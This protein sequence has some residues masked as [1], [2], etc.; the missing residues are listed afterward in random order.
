MKNIGSKK[1]IVPWML[2][3]AGFA[4]IFNPNITVFDFLPDFIGYI[5]VVV[6]LTK[7]SMMNE[8]LADAKKLFEKM[9]L[10]DVGKYLAIFWIF[11]MEAGASKASSY[12]LWSFVFAVLEIIF[13]IPSYLKLFKGISELGDI[14]ESDYIHANNGKGKSYTEKIRNF[15][16]FFVIFKAIMTVLPELTD[17]GSSS[18]TNT[19]LG[20]EYIDLYRYIGIIRFLCYVPVIILGIA[21]LVRVIMYFAKLSKDSRLNS[22]LRETY[23]ERVAA[24][25]GLFA[26]R[27]VKIASWLM[28]AAAVVSL[29]VMFDEINILPDVLAV[30][31][32]IPAIIFFAKTAEIKKGGVCLSAIVFGIFSVGAYVSK[33]LFMNN[34]HYT[35]MNKDFLAFALYMLYVLLT[36]LQS[37]MFIVMYSC[38]IK[39]IR[40]VTE[41]NTGYVLGQSISSDVERK[42]VKEVHDEINKSFEWL[43]NVA[44]IYAVSEFLATLYGILYAFPRINGMFLVAINIICGIVFIFFT[45]RALDDLKDSMK[46]KYMLE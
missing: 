41:E 1:N 28:I 14:Y 40:K 2:L 8:T 6:A 7:V 24:K 10:L 44:I 12:L 23:S 25:R 17:L 22:A 29:D 37:V 38:L 9:I 15:T 20:Q 45:V 35:A 43:L 34:F 36:V 5:L 4:F 46:I 3:A 31:F 16:V 26:I 32:I 19:F 33:A 27:N 39:Q 11:G 21:W 30:A 18:N 42:Q 13:L